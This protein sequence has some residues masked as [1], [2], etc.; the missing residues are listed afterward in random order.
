MLSYNYRSTVVSPEG[1]VKSQTPW[2]A[3]EVY[4]R[5]NDEW[6]IV[7]T[8]W[9][10]ISHRLPERVEIPLTIETSPLKYERVLGELMAL[11]LGAMGRWHKGDPW[12]FTD[13]SAPEVTYFD[14]G[15]P[16][17]I[18]GLE[19][20]LI[21][22]GQR[23]SLIYYDLMDFIE[24]QVRFGGDLAVLYYR[25][26]STWVNPDGVIAQR[27]PWNCSEVYQRM[28]EGWRIIHTHWSFIRGERL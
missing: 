16:Q 9:S 21:E 5:R 2:N 10:Y 20:L 6:R 8:H 15:T 27:T 22:Y 25:Y 3:T 23:E 4:F 14:P 26:L 11:E 13:I 1:E 12:G 17:R 7:H 24:P 28:D 19:A 18:N